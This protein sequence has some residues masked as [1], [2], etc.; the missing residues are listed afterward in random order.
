MV[1]GIGAG[2]RL[3][4]FG[5]LNAIRLC[6]QKRLRKEIFLGKNFFSV[7]TGEHAESHHA[8]MSLTFLSN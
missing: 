6:W 5:A 1:V 8:Q 2:R 4:D 7:E 3:L